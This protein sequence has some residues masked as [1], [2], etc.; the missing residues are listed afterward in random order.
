MTNRTVNIKTIAYFDE[1]WYCIENGSGCVTQDMMDIYQHC[2]GVGDEI[3]Y[4]DGHLYFNR[5]AF[6]NIDLMFTNYNFIT[7]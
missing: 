1:L 5:D 3:H 7:I 4:I 6:F 2:K